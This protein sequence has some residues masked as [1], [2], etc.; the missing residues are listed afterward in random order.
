MPI[1]TFKI[2]LYSYIKNSVIFLFVIY[3]KNGIVKKK[4][5]WGTYLNPEASNQVGIIGD[6]WFNPFILACSK[7]MF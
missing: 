1:Q 4:M 5:Q 6:A 7:I 2:V 3:G